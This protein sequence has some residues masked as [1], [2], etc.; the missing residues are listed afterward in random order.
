MTAPRH[1][2]DGSTA[3]AK[4]LETIHLSDDLSAQGPISISVHLT[5]KEKE[6]LRKCTDDLVVK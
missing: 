5:R 1:M 3:I 6:S 4:Q 2:Q